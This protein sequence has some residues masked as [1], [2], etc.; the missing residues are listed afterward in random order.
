MKPWCEG[1][2]PISSQRNLLSVG[3]VKLETGING[4]QTDSVIHGKG[5]HG[6]WEK[7]Y[8]GF[9]DVSC[10]TS[11]L[12]LIELWLSL[13]SASSYFMRGEH[14][15][16]RLS[17]RKMLVLL[18]DAIERNQLQPCLPIWSKEPWEGN[19]SRAVEGLAPT[20][21]PSGLSLESG[22]FQTPKSHHFT[23]MV[24]LSDGL[25]FWGAG[26]GVN[27]YYDNCSIM[28]VRYP[29]RIVGTCGSSSLLLKCKAVWWIL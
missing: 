21:D 23:F 6:P 29:R 3:K 25:E 27:H 4:K 24:F 7:G 22:A 2:R 16:E 20:P 19:I 8:F 5:R 26:H 17:G 9:L 1:S 28:K 18:Y 13:S 12:V 14:L 15:T 11:H 10:A